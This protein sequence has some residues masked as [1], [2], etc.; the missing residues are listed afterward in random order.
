MN[1]ALIRALMFHISCALAFA[2]Q[3]GIVHRDMKPENVLLTETGFPKIADFGLSKHLY[4]DQN[5]TKA[6]TPAYAAPEVM[7]GKYGFPV[8]VFSTGKILQDMMAKDYVVEWMFNRLPPGERPNYTK[9]WKGGVG[10]PQFT[11]DLTNLMKNMTRDSASS[12]P[13]FYQVCREIESMGQRHRLPHPFWGPEYLSRQIR[14]QG[15]PNYAYKTAKCPYGIG[16]KVSVD[17]TGMGWVNGVVDHVGERLQPGAACIKYQ[18]NGKEEVVLIPPNQIKTRIRKQGAASGRAAPS[19]GN[20]PC[21][22]I[23]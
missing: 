22:V 23:C 14:A 10:K 20:Q 4:A 18:R 17:I 1:E 5:N 13:T 12:R 8:D 16:E 21:C 3:Q 9:Q 19:G 11:A 7:S 15:P 6:G 2:H